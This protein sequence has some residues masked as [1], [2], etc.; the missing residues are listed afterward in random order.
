MRII[1]RPI[2]AAILSFGAFGLGAIL[3]VWPREVADA[4]RTLVVG[5]DRGDVHWPVVL[6]WL[7]VFLWTIFLYLRLRSE[8][9]T[10][11]N[12]FD[13][14]TGA[15][16]RSPNYSVFTIYPE[17]YDRAAGAI[18]GT[19][20]PTEPPE[21]RIR[22][23]SAGIQLVLNLAASMASEFTLAPQKKAYGANIMLVLKPPFPQAVL[24]HLR[25]FDQEHQD[26]NSSLLAVLYMPKKLLLTDLSPFPKRTVPCISLPVPRS[27]RDRRGNRLA[28]PGAPWALL[29]GTQSAQVDT[30]LM[31]AEC[32][33]LPQSTIAEVAEYFHAGGLGENVKSFVSFRIGDQKNPVGVLNIDCSEPNVLGAELEYYQTFYALVS[34]IVRLLSKPLVDFGR[35]TTARG[36]YFGDDEKQE[37]I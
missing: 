11:S 2:A 23:L 34:P 8:D 15:I 9:Q 19:H 28:L 33:G 36:E 31:A 32:E 35:L 16:H 1:S 27:A 21:V 24:K 12:R 10:Q 29:T 30:Q 6:F 25:F 5:S 14:L 7:A 4:T 26:A 20:T 22:N 37:H 18:A 17:Y 3:S 13:Q